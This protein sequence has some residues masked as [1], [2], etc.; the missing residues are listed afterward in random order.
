[1]KVRSIVLFCTRRPHIIDQIQDAENGSWVEVDQSEVNSFE[2]INILE[3]EGEELKEWKSI[4]LYNRSRFSPETLALIDSAENGTIILV[5]QEELGA[6][7]PMLI[8]KEG[9]RRHKNQLPHLKISERD[10]P[11]NRRGRPPGAKNKPKRVRK[12]HD[13]V[14]TFLSES[15]SES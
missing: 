6:S 11:A 7:Y 1:M 2:I 10:L 14:E 8:H 4:V 3:P 5:K 13:P 15:Q 12:L 9:F